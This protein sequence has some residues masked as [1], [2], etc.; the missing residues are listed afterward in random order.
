[1]ETEKRLGIIGVGNMGE[2]LLKGW[3]KAGLTEPELIRVFDLSSERR[4]MAR[5]SISR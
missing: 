5:Q 2:S 4:K 1:M 3:L